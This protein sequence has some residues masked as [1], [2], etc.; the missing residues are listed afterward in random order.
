MKTDVAN[1]KPKLRF[2]YNVKLI[3]QIQKAY[4]FYNVKYENFAKIYQLF[5]TKNAKISQKLNS[6]FLTL[7]YTKAAAAAAVAFVRLNSLNDLTYSPF[8]IF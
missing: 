3:L 7:L 1:I 5:T 2:F 8:F 4:T 6:F